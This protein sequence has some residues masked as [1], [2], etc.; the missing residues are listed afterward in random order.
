MIKDPRMTA[1]TLTFNTPGEAWA[2]AGILRYLSTN[3][4]GIT[5]VETAL[6][7]NVCDQIQAQVKL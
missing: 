1:V 5:S 6:F 4:D 7:Q 3:Y 2:F